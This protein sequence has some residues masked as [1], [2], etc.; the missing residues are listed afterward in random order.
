MAPQRQREGARERAT[1]PAWPDPGLNLN[2]NR[3]LN[4]NLDVNLAF[5]LPGCVLWQGSSDLGVRLSPTG[6]PLRAVHRGLARG[7]GP[8]APQHARG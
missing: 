2:L 1:C 5:N 6:F 4:R 7:H 8:K 3:N